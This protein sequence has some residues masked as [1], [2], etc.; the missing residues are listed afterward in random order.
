MHS[1]ERTMKTFYEPKPRGSYDL[2][3]SQ[4]SCS[5]TLRHALRSPQKLKLFGD[6][7]I[8]ITNLNKNF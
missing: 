1:K 4:R 7:K 6:P 3:D 5:M 2:R 8:F